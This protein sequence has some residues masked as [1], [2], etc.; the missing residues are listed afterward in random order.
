MSRY[1]ILVT[2]FVVLFASCR[3]NPNIQGKGA[4]FLQGVWAE[5]SVIYR[6]DLLQYTTHEYKFTCDSFY[7]TF[8]TFA[9]TN[10][11]PDSCF[12]NGRWV[13]YAK[14]VYSVSNDS[15]MFVGTFTKPN[16]KQKISGCY[17][18]GQY[19]ET[20]I[21]RDRSP[22]S[23]QLSSLTQHRPLQLMLKEKTTCIPKPLN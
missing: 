12:N 19:L 3:F 14:G 9:K 10:I 2:F 5:D 6:R 4:D 15:L 11:Y 13:E 17:R 8:N 1:F 20:Y 22:E 23:I 21:I 7:V 18:I 16:F